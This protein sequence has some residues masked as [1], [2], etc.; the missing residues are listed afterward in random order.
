M[1]RRA[2]VILFLV[3]AAVLGGCT[4]PPLTGPP[5]LRVGRDECIECGMLVAEDRFSSASIVERQGERSYVFFDDIGCMLDYEYEQQGQVR[6]VERYVHDHDT[7]AWVPGLE[8]VYVFADRD[9]LRTPMGSGI[10]ACADR[11]AAEAL[12]ARHKGTLHDFRSLAVVRREWMWANFG[13]PADAR[14]V[15]PP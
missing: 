7:R 8:A 6:V 5:N 3:A 14:P 13:K 9:S 10:A 12:A 2:V 4:R 1:N 11:A 15:P